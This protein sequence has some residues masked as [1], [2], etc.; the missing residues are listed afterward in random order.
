MRHFLKKAL[1]LKKFFLIFLFFNNQI[2]SSDLNQFLNWGSVFQINHFGNFNLCFGKDYENLMNLSSEKFSPE[3]RED[4]DYLISISK[5]V[6]AKETED[7]LKLYPKLKTLIS[8]DLIS[9][10]KLILFSL[11]A[12]SATW[13]YLE[14]KNYR[15]ANDLYGEITGK[16]LD[17]FDKGRYV[18]GTIVRLK[19]DLN[20]HFKTFGLDEDFYQAQE[21]LETF[22]LSSMNLDLQDKKV[23][24]ETLLEIRIQRLSVLQFDDT[25]S[26]ERILAELNSI[27]TNYLYGHGKKEF[28]YSEFHN[29]VIENA[30]KENLLEKY[31]QLLKEGDLKELKV[32]ISLQPQHLRILLNTLVNLNNLKLDV[33]QKYPRRLSNQYA[34][35]P[36]KENI[37]EAF[38]LLSYW[39]EEDVCDDSEKVISQISFENLNL[40]DFMSYENLITKCKSL[41]N[42]FSFEKY[43]ENLNSRKDEIKKDIKVMTELST[44]ERFEKFESF[45]FGKNYENLEDL[46]FY[47]Q[48][49]YA[50]TLSEGIDFE[51]YQTMIKNQMKIL[52]F[53][54]NKTVIKEHS[55]LAI[56]NRFLT[57]IDLR[58]TR[59]FLDTHKKRLSKIKNDYKELLREKF[60]LNINELIKKI[61]S[62][63]N[64]FGTYMK[65]FGIQISEYLG[66]QL[67]SIIIDSDGVGIDGYFNLDLKKL[68]RSRLKE[69]EGFVKENEPLLLA[70]L[71]QSYKEKNVKPKFGIE[72]PLIFNREIS[73]FRNLQVWGLYFLWLTEYFA[74]RNLESK[75][76]PSSWLNND[77]ENLFLSYSWSHSPTKLTYA[78]FINHLKEIYKELDEEDVISKYAKSLKN[79]NRF[80]ESQINLKEP[81]KNAKFLGNKL[82]DKA[83]DK[84]SEIYNQE[85]FE[86]EKFLLPN[87]KIEDYQRLL[88][89]DEAISV[90]MSA[91]SGQGPVMQLFIDKN[92]ARV[93]PAGWNAEDYQIEINSILA[94]IDL[95][96]N[97]G[98]SDTSK[99]VLEHMYFQFLSPIKEFKKIYLITDKTFSKI[100][101]SLFIDENGNFAAER[102]SFVMLDSI[103]S[104]NF[105]QDN[106]NRLSPSMKFIGIG[107]PNLKGNSNE[108]KFKNLFLSRG[109]ADLNQINELS[110]LPN[111][112]KEL[113]EI[114]KIFS[115]SELFLS[116]FASE[117]NLNLPKNKKLLSEGK[118]ISFATHTFSDKTNFSRE[119]GLVLTPPK[120]ASKDNDG[121]LTSSEISNL[122]FQDS[123]II[124][125]ACDTD[126]PIFHNAGIF[127]GL[128]RAFIEAGATSVLLTQWNV[129]SN[130][131]RIF[132]TEALKN[133]IKNKLGLSES[134]SETMKKFINGSFGEE[135]KHPYY[136]SPFLVLGN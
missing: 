62:N 8:D 58:F 82:V 110:S 129:E 50:A 115:S 77:L 37:L 7:A 70:A 130:S 5:F 71:N 125:S 1:K 111:T 67:R 11:F 96:Q 56:L 78:F 136:W 76:F 14:N 42:K 122:S 57:L 51:I 118:I 59:P 93:L 128:P 30:A 119:Q 114:A 29:F 109:L 86:P 81:D 4:L 108:N 85:F 18:H 19:K 39:L 116:D 15:L 69:I 31:E 54:P 103:I 13:A 134:I 61:D 28:E 47:I 104:F 40:R 6:C 101:F 90:L 120:I 12:K 98:L 91:P 65:R 53:F 80:K 112:K 79:L 66:L 48:N 55:S 132:M 10:N 64:S 121:L 60:D 107:D 95:R 73:D 34:L 45:S 74:E 135:Y 133:G 117:A 84:L 131:T 52:D 44:K 97:K 36:E 63:E 21:L 124:L 72:E 105:L 89:E 99:L 41:K 20:Q 17:L 127:S 75:A 24:A 88:K 92:L 102:H 46:S 25:K 16:I 123:I 83:L 100:P 26:V 23:L 33:D 38:S 68:S 3:E 126:K 2:F 27:F 43:L 9:E 49:K 106:V 94:D 35:R 32:K 22:I 87:L 113:E